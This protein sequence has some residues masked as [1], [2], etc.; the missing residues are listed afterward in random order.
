MFEVLNFL[1]NLC[2]DLLAW[3]S[4]KQQYAARL[5]IRNCNVAIAKAEQHMQKV[6]AQHE[7]LVCKLQNQRDAMQ[8]YLDSESIHL[9]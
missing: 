1:V 5:R 4:A 3:L 6:Q 2:A 8:Y 7:E 9:K